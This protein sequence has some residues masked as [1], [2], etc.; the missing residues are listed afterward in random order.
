MMSNNV[1]IDR[2]I[3]RLRGEEAAANRANTEEDFNK[4]KA[5]SVP[6]GLKFLGPKARPFR[7]SG[8]W[9]RW[10]HELEWWER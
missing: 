8:T 1:L 2:E 4:L 7:F 5:D 10:A 3:A 6:A 9:P